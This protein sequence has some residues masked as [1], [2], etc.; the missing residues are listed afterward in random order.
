MT[1]DKITN[2]K[3]NVSPYKTSLQRVVGK[4]T[5]I[6]SALCRM[7]GSTLERLPKIT[8]RTMKKKAPTLKEKG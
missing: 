5:Y 7:K 1:H 6:K 8:F 4:E 2:I 3:V